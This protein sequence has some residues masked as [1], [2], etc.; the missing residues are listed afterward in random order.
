MNKY[1]IGISIGELQQWLADDKL[2]IITDRITHSRSLVDASLSGFELENLFISLPAFSL[3]DVAG[4]LIAEI[5]SP[6][7]W[8]DDDNQKIRYL[9]LS[10]IKRFIPLTDDAKIALSVTWSKVIVLS[11][12]I[13]EQHFINFRINK[14][15]I[16]AGAAGNHFASFFIDHGH[17]GFATPKIFTESL[18][19]ALM[20]AEHRNTAE[21]EKLRDRQNVELSETWLERAFG[22]IKKYDLKNKF[23]ILRQKPKNI[24]DIASVGLLFSAVEEV[25]ALKNT[26]LEIYIRLDGTLKDHDQSLALVYA[27]S[28]LSQLKASFYVYPKGSDSISLV[29]LGLFLRWKQAYHDQRSNVNAQSILNDVNSL[30]GLVDVDLVANALWMMGAYLGMENITPTYRYLHQSE[31]PALRFA[32]NENT[33]KPVTAWQLKVTQLAAGHELSPH[34]VQDSEATKT[35]EYESALKENPETTKKQQAAEQ[36]KTNVPETKQS[37]SGQ[38]CVTNDAE[39]STEKSS[40]SEYSSASDILVDPENAQT[41]QDQQ[42]VQTDNAIS[43]PP[44]EMIENVLDLSVAENFPAEGIKISEASLNQGEENIQ[45]PAPSAPSV[46]EGKTEAGSI[47]S[48][49]GTSQVSSPK[50]KSTKRNNAGPN[51]NS[52]IKAS[53]T[54]KNENNNLNTEGVSSASTAKPE[55]SHGE[56]EGEGESGKADQNELPFLGL[57]NAQKIISNPD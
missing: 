30:V 12:A 1:F 46:S 42:V 34:S 15:S 3:D 53:S 55:D 19:R 57:V 28:E 50:R 52:T 32:N 49:Q 44:K 11:E 13:F 24:R 27:D 51:K 22:D 2:P 43:E 31:Y 16:L 36:E 33:L 26:L 4:V 54:K 25:K 47:E 14:K 18:P 39:K 9:K 35:P 45:L 20:A 21:I 6:D 29:T 48:L 5:S 37:E 38:E 10:D 56:L 7:T 23:A 41:Q 8:G 17:E 40:S